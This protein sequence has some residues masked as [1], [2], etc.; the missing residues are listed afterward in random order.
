MR[1]VAV[2][3]AV[4]L[5]AAGEPVF[6]DASSAL[7]VPHVY[8]G[9]WEHF[10]GGGIAVFDCD[11]DAF[12]DFLAAGGDAPAT[13]FR[14]VTGSPGGDLA[15]STESIPEITGVT[16]AYPLNIDGDD[17]T[18]LVMLRVGGNRLWKGSADCRFEDHTD[19]WRLAGH[20]AW[21]TAFSATW[22]GDLA[23]PT[24]FFGNYVDR[25]DPE[26]PFGACDDNEVLRPVDGTYSEV[27]PLSPGYCAL[28]MLVSDWQRSG[29][30]E[31]RIS[32][33]RH[34]YLKGGYEE[35]W[36]LNPL[37]PRDESDGWDRISLWGMGIASADL[38]N[39]GLPEVML[40]SMGDQVLQI[41]EG[42]GFRN[43]PYSIGTYAATP[44]IGDDGRPS[45]GWHAEFGDVNNDGLLDLFIAKGN[46]DQMPS[47]A[48]RDPNNLL[49]QNGEGR[50]QE[51][52]AQA[53]VSTSERARGAALA[54][55]NLDGLLDILV[56]NRRAP[57]EVWQ[58]QTQGAGNW[59]Q[60]SLEQGAPNR[61]AIGAWIEVSVGDRILSREVTVGGGHAGGTLGPAHFGL[62]NAERVQVR[63]IWPDGE[64]SGWSDHPAN[65]RV[66]IMRVDG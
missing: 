29:A 23:M 32:N 18:D 61:N 50:F 39:D 14:N 26:G 1:L 30:P 21:T 63:V 51:R 35:I 31:L 53:G 65:R 19:D 24:L 4:P 48:M 10:V 3:L 66:K 2:L 54:D 17:H 57:L 16:G 44:H 7:P 9:G 52:A 36:R 47:N 64:T 62:G 11:G 15:F 34:Y 22:E 28:S 58:N 41:N 20:D 40:T 45:T 42:D 37:S 59:L 6:R 8:A 60:I 43:A 12:P 46:V 25:H 27:I 33:D 13:L 55:L 56:V 49:I 5:A 38:T